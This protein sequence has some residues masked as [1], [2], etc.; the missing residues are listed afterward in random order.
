M[1]YPFLLKKTPP[2]EYSDGKIYGKGFEKAM[3]KFKRAGSVAQNA[4][5]RLIRLQDP[6]NP[7]AIGSE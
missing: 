5:V 3:E 1:S 6:V 7:R 2:W 4:N